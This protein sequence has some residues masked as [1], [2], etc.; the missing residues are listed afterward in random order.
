MEEIHLDARNILARRMTG[1][2]DVYRVSKGRVSLPNRERWFL[3]SKG[4]R[5]SD[6]AAKKRLEKKKNLAEKKKRLFMGGNARKKAIEEGLCE[7]KACDSHTERREK[8][9]RPKMWKNPQREKSVKK[10]HI[11]VG[12]R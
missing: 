12:Y 7:R 3:G 8:G 10:K 11:C 2:H 9:K 4:G 1:G 6:S 5:G